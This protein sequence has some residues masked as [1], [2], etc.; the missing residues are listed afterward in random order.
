LAL[1]PF[2]IHQSSIINMKPPVPARQHGSSIV[3]VTVGTGLKIKTF[4]VHKNLLCAVS[5]YF[6]NALQK[7]FKEQ[8]EGKVELTDQC[9]HAFATLYHYIYS[10]EVLD[11]EF[12]TEAL[13]AEDVHWLRTLKLA[14]YVGI[15]ALVVEAYDR[16]KE[17]FSSGK[18]ASK[19]PT[20][21]FIKELYDDFPQV[22]IQRYIVAHTVYWIANDSSTDWK[23][24]KERFEIKADYGMDVAIHY[25]KIK[26]KVYQAHKSHPDDDAAMLADNLYPDPKGKEVPE[27]KER[28]ETW[29]SSDE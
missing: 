19:L 14:D 29:S 17:L 16:L 10:G 18:R 4:R 24:W 22:P 2:I 15:N 1:T 13:V 21:T 12:Y 9:P 7:D 3:T 26:S 23:D 11:A 5:E 6:Q 28:E 25:A 27:V 20:L 8:S